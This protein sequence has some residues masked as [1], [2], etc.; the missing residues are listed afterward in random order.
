MS[1]VSGNDVARWVGVARATVS[2]VLNERPDKTISAANRRRVLEA[3]REPGY[4]PSAAAAAL[5]VGRSRVV[6]LV[7]GV[8]TPGPAETVL[9]LGDGGGRRR[10]MAE[11]TTESRRKAPPNDGQGCHQATT[12]TATKPRCLSLRTRRSC[13]RAIWP[14]APPSSSHT[15][16]P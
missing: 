14:H 11:G 15:S 2:D 13:C 8:R 6:V 3:A 9:P 7:E 4:V 10:A 16:L 1:R 5:S 12:E